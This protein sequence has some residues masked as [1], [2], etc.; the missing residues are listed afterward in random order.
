MPAKR[1]QIVLAALFASGSITLP[2]GLHAQ[3]PPCTLEE[4]QQF[5]FWIGSWRVESPTGAVVGHNVIRRVN[6]CVL[7]ESYSTPTGYSGESFNIYD[8][9]RGVWHQSWVDN[10]GLLL[11]L[12]GGLEDGKMVLEGPGVAQNGSAVVHRI[13]WSVVD[14]DAAHIRQ[15]WETSTDDGETRAVSF[16]GHYRREGSP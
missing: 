12:D 6:N 16:D 2:A 5:D 4:Y 3:T 1:F 13:T 9:A 11:Q 10:G 7:H 14:G 15:L 8:R